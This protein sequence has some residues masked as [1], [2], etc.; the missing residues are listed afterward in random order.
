[1]SFIHITTFALISPPPP[2]PAALTLTIHNL[3]VSDVQMKTQRVLF[4]PS[5]HLSDVCFLLPLYQ[6]AVSHLGR[7]NHTQA[8]L[9]ENMPIK[10]VQ[11]GHPGTAVNFPGNKVNIDSD[12]STCPRVTTIT[13]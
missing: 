5:S 11:R 7:I 8:A 10:F 12:I 4:M 3:H 6:R 1:M 13:F 9:C 2:P